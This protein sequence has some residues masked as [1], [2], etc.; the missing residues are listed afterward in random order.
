ML[1]LVLEPNRKK[2]EQKTVA[3]K[4]C[5]AHQSLTSEKSANLPAGRQARRFAPQTCAFLTLPSRRCATE[6]F[7]GDDSVLS[8]PAP[9]VLQLSFVK[10]CS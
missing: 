10:E 1:H 5:P 9:A 7:Q 2:V 6:F 4:K 3:V 8:E